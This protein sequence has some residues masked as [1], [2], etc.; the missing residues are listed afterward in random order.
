[1]NVQLIKVCLGNI[2]LNSIEKKF[3]KRD[4]I[5]STF[6][7]AVGAG[8][9][10]Q[11]YNNNDFMYKLSDTVITSLHV[12]LLDQN[13]NFILFNGVEWYLSLNISFQ[14]K[15]AL[16]PA[17]YL[18]DMYK[19]NP[20]EY[21]TAEDALYQEEKRHNDELADTIIRENKLLQ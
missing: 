8:E 5:L 19:N 12:Q 20:E 4:N 9:I 16:I 6:R 3:D 17:Y 10:Q 11:F 2:Y 1:M 15:K 21:G 18:L 14:Y 7:V 13:D